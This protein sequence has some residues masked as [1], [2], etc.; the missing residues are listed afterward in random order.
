MMIQLRDLSED[1]RKILKEAIPLQ[2]NKNHME[3]KRYVELFHEFQRKTNFKYL[4]SHGF[5]GFKCAVQ[6]YKRKM[7]LMLWKNED[8]EL[9]TKDINNA[10]ELSN[11]WEQR[12]ERIINEAVKNAVAKTN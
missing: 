12:K 10:W 11:K 5:N 2:S 3:D 8:N 4:H 9:W 1:A 6:E 7:P